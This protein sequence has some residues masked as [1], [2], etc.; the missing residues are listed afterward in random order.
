MGNKRSFFL[1]YLPIFLLIFSNLGCPPNNIYVPVPGERIEFDPANAQDASPL[2]STS[3]GDERF[4][5]VSPDG[6]YVAL[7]S[8][9]LAIGTQ[10]GCFTTDVYVI[11]ASGGNMRQ[12]TQ[13]ELEQEVLYPYWAGNNRIL[14]TRY[15]GYPEFPLNLYFHD[16]PSQTME[17][18]SVLRREQT[19][20]RSGS[21]ISSGCPSPDGKKIAI[22][23]DF[24]P[25]R[26]GRV[27]IFRRQPRLENPLIIIYDLATKSPTEFAS[28][29]QPVWSPDGKKIAY[30]KKVG[31]NFFIYVKDVETKE[32][33]QITS[34][35]DAF[36][37][38]PC[39]SPS[40][41]EIAFASWR[42]GD[43]DIWK[44]GADGKN[45]MRLTTSPGTE[46]DPSWGLGGYIYFSFLRRPQDW[47]IWRIK[48][49]SLR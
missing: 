14:Y 49:V 29:M 26:K 20:W 9:P 47:D 11:D 19:F 4:P 30:S 44:V 40:G 45:L 38:M 2:T 36:D 34:G 23:I 28:G 6:K 39:W 31:M 42:T 33:R 37:W 8:R 32:E 13:T 16:F 46:W 12:I 25:Y 22:C 35:T 10:Q 7:V 41:N 5:Q 17:G 15:D 3:A 24:P 18:I 21:W 48:V 43:W 27:D 1:F